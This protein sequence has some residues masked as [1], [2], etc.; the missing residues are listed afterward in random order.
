LAALADGFNDGNAGHNL[1]SIQGIQAARLS[2][3]ILPVD[4]LDPAWPAIT[5]ATQLGRRLHLLVRSSVPLDENRPIAL[6]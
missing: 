1:R 6:T 4:G 3:L 5:R 2:I